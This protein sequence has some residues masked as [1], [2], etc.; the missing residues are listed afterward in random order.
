M[1]NL[2]KE[3]LQAYTDI[4]NE[5]LAEFDVVESPHVFERLSA[6]EIR[7]IFEV[8]KEEEKRKSTKRLQELYRGQHEVRSTDVH[9][10][11]GA[12]IEKV[13]VVTL[14]GD[15]SASFDHEGE[16]VHF[17]ITLDDDESN[18]DRYYRGFNDGYEFVKSGQADA[19]IKAAQAE[20]APSRPPELSENEPDKIDDD[21]WFGEEWP[22]TSD[23]DET[24]P[25]SDEKLTNTPVPALV[26]M[27]R[28]RI[29][30]PS[31]YGPGHSEVIRQQEQ[32]SPQAAAIFG[33]EHTIVSPLRSPIGRDHAATP[34]KPRTLA[35]ADA[36]ADE[37]SEIIVAIQEMADAG[38]MP[39]VNKY[40]KNKP[41]HLP[42][43]QTIIDRHGITFW[44]R[45]A[46]M[47]GL[48]LKG[49]KQQMT[50][51]R[52]AQLERLKDERKAEGRG[53]HGAIESDDGHHTPRG[54]YIPTEAEL[55]AELQRQAMAGQIMP[56]VAQFDSARPANWAT[57]QAHML[58]LN[59]GWNE[60]AKLAG[61][62]PN[63]RGF[64]ATQPAEREQ[65][66]ACSS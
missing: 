59:V 66:N 35:D 61:L 52:R 31:T 20:A 53:R 23:G 26:P 24:P 62:K 49:K 17:R 64:K 43:W 41:E 30:Y 60:L 18:A 11:T 38:V 50:D 25:R 44:G 40:N 2:T 58:R 27:P 4:I 16:Q 47:C 33:P 46:E 28:P 9:G 55:L 19:V 5:R 51:A 48:E 65:A 22:R 37:L 29:S 8:F 7:I 34:A 57:A 39:H 63:P 1:G 56:T 45:M 6:G 32:V 10:P 15:G 36:L 14:K 54:S 12:A 13:G 42:H 21:G 3:Q